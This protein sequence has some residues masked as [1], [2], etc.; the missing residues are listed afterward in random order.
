MKLSSF[1]LIVLVLFI[2]LAFTYAGTDFAKY[3]TRVGKKFLDENAQKD[4]VIVLPSGLQYKVL[5]AGPGAE[6]PTA[7]DTVKVHYRG[8][9][10]GGKEFDSSYSRGEP[11]SF[12][13]GQVIKGWTEALTLMHVGDVWELYIPSELGYGPRGTGRDIGPN[14]VL[15][16]KVEL[17]EIK[18]HSDL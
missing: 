8:S 16:F 12:G 10:I 9:L 14:S 13:V 1:S 2:T 11:S 6:T 7:R 18:K 3:N 15:I 17:L 5:E 4:G